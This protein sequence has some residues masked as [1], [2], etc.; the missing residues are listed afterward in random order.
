VASTQSSTSEVLTNLNKTNSPSLA[1]P[2]PL[3]QK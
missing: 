3:H 1:V 2:I